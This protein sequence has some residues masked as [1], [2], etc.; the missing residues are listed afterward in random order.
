MD[1]FVQFLG[2]VLFISS[3]PGYEA[4]LPAVDGSG[5][6]LKHDALILAPSGHLTFS[7]DGWKTGTLTQRDG[8]HTWDYGELHG[9]E[10]SFET[11][12]PGLSPPSF[13]IH[14]NDDCCRVMGSVRTEYLQPDEIHS[15]ATVLID[16]GDANWSISRGGR[17][18]TVV[19]MSSSGAELVVNVKSKKTGKVRYASLKDDAV[20]ANFPIKYITT[21]NPPEDELHFMRYYQMVTFGFFC[22]TNPKR[23]NQCADTTEQYTARRHDPIIGIPNFK[24]GEEHLS[25]IDIACSNSQYP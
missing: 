13:L 23:G 15:A 2:L 20:I 25:A 11:N 9:D 7:G 24:D 8:I 18:D 6:I 4:L 21:D 17:V 22:N 5:N 1:H 19:K 14:I 16:D 3:S 10:I 12:G